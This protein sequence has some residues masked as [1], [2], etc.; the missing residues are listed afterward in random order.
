VLL[1]DVMAVQLDFGTPRNR[2]IRSAGAAT[3]RE[4]RFVSGSMAPKVEAAARFADATGRSALIDA[5][6]EARRLPPVAAAPRSGPAGR[7]PVP[8]A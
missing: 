7:H 6:K 2:A 4:Y 5:L 8:R 3:V 1:T